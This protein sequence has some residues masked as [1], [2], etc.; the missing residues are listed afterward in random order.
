[1][2]THVSI[3]NRIRPPSQGRPDR[4]G[5]WPKGDGQWS[6][7]QDAA[8]QTRT[9]VA[10]LGRG[11]LHW[12]RAEEPAPRSRNARRGRAD[13]TGA[14]MT[15][16]LTFY[17]LGNADTT[18]IRLCNDDLVLF[19]YADRRDPDDPYDKRIDLPN[20][21]RDQL[22]DAGR[23]AFR[24]VAFTHLDDDHICG[25]SD[26]F[27]FDYNKS[28]QGGDRVQMEEMWVPAYAI[29]ET[30]VSGD[31]WY[32]RQEAR[33]RLREGYGIKVFSR[34]EQLK[35]ILEGWG[36]TLEE[37]RHCIV[38]AGKTVPGFSLTGSERAEFFVHSPFAWRTDEG[39]ED[40][41]QNSIVVQMT[42][43]E[44]G[45]DSYAFLGADVDYETLSQI[46]ETSRRHDNE[47]RLTWDVLKLFH[48][49][50]Y[51]ALSDEKG[52]DIT[53]PVDDVRDLFEEFS[54]EKAIIVSPSKPIPAKGTREDDDVQPPHRQAANYYRGVVK[55]IGGEFKVTMETPS[56]AKPK[57]LKVKVSASGVALAM[58]AAP[59]V[60]A[61]TSSQTT[62]AG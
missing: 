49:C 21:L 40:R 4:F 35:K 42:L 39:L 18:L 32:I 3:V 43:R 28:L 5:S 53:D 41:N 45:N 22:A 59:N 11:G 58:V 17:P 30:D 15:A 60:A 9:V 52:E 24:V 37:R 55:D 10:P 16:Y 29:T 61:A 14:T 36:L 27:H 2:V 8:A 47:H 57:P 13:L 46:V 50:S 51:T 56:V 31:A 48:H 19:D 7:E 26:F 25:A 62:R 34:P 33:H 23:E 44:G 38:D 20:A 1:M 54:R 12:G 6:F